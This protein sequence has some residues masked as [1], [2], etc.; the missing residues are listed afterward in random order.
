MNAM[1]ST[2]VRI[3]VNIEAEHPSGQ[4]GATHCR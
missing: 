2:T 3:V 1:A 4:V